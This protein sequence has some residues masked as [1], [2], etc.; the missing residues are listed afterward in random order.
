MGPESTWPRRRLR[1][2]MT[3]SFL[4]AA[5]R[6]ADARGDACRARRGCGEGGVGRWARPRPG[7]PRVT[8]TEA[9][10]LGIASC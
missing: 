9:D 8:T 1:A 3:P 6:R 5:R 10:R 2:S 4:R 7:S